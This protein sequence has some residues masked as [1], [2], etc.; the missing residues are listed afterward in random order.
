M[1]PGGMRRITSIPW[2]SCGAGP[3]DQPL[4]GANDVAC[5]LWDYQNWDLDEVL[6][7]WMHVLGDL[8]IYC[9]DPA[10]DEEFHRKMEKARL[11]NGKK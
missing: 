7:E 5:L 4:G 10:P 1:G 6:I 2:T 9:N 8:R 3:A 11:S